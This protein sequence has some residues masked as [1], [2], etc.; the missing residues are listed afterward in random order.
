MNMKIHKNIDKDVHRRMHMSIH[1]SILMMSNHN[2]SHLNISACSRNRIHAIIS[3]LIRR[4]QRVC[5]PKN[6]HGAVGA[7]ALATAASVQR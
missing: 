7:F 2:I 1:L 5:I 6:S 4:S 3:T